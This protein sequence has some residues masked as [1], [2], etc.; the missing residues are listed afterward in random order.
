MSSKR[1]SIV[2]EED[3]EVQKINPWSSDCYC[4]FDGRVE[5]VHELHEFI[6]FLGGCCPDASYC[7]SSLYL[8][9]G[10]IPFSNLVMNTSKMSNFKGDPIESL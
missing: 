4:E 7:I 8:R 5:N 10:E 2:M 6:D 3:R 1:E 9:Q